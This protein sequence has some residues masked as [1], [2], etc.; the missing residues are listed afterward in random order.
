MYAPR[1]FV[2]MLAVLIVFAVSSYLIHGSIVTALIQTLICT[3]IIQAGYF[4]GIFYLVR[5]EK[6]RSE[7]IPARESILLRGLERETR[8][9]IQPTVARNFQARDR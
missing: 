2:S 4:V 3:V 8:E 5:R 7:G 9:E 1:V 6:L